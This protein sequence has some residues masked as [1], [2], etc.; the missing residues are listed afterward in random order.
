MQ[1]PQAI[2]VSGQSIEDGDSFGEWYTAHA[3]SVY[4]TSLAILK[5]PD[6]A[7]DVALDVF[8]RAWQQPGQYDPSRGSAGV[9]LRAVARNLSID[10][11]RSA[12]RQVAPDGVLDRSGTPADEVLSQLLAR[13]QLASVRRAIHMLPAMYRQLIEMA[14]D[15]ELSHSEI[16][17]DLRHPLGT[18]KSRIRQALAMLRASPR[19]GAGGVQLDTPTG[20]GV[21]HTCFD[22]QQLDD[23]KNR[24][25]GSGAG[26]SCRSPQHRRVGRIRV[27]GMRRAAGRASLEQRFQGR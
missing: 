25:C 26:E 24:P 9:W 14:Y 15:R 23:E 7:R 3:H 11:L 21:R 1:L 5:N 19:A 8:L 17:K 10:R 6:V 16:A 13:E 18:V 4:I 20:P 12:R 2:V 22:V 27:Q